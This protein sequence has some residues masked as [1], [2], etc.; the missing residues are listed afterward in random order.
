M[1]EWRAKEDEKPDLNVRIYS[2]GSRLNE[3]KQYANV[4]I[5]PIALL[6]A[7]TYPCV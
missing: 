3:L 1:N 6:K 4:K 5:I 2:F 7:V